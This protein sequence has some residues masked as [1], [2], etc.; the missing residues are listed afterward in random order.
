METPDFGETKQLA[1][2][3]H[4]AAQINLGILYKNGQGVTHDYTIAH[5]WFNIATAN[6]YADAA[7]A[8][9]LL[10]KEMTAASIT[11]AQ[12]MARECLGSDYR[13]CGVK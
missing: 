3:G 10:A 11:K 12:E 7:K 1:E 4:A 6:G 13:D 5:M 9:D 2:Q 8:R